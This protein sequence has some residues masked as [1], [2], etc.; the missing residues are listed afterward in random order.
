MVPQK[1]LLRHHKG[2]AFQGT[3]KAHRKGTSKPSE[4]PQRS[5]KMKIKLNFLFQYNFQISDIEIF[6]ITLRFVIYVWYIAFSK[7]QH[8]T[9]KTCQNNMFEV[10]NLNI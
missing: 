3:S 5:V 9:K 7:Q 6:D 8:I 1:V 10:N 2:N 4:A